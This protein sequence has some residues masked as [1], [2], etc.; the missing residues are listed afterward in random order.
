MQELNDEEKLELKKQNN[1]E[2]MR[3]YMK[4]R[5]HANIEDSQKRLNNFYYRKTNKD[6]VSLEDMKKYGNDFPI[7]CK[8]MKNILILKNKN[9]QLIKEILQNYLQ[10]CENDEH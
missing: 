8:V 7:V 1:R 9:P 10:E 2:Y 4:K 6:I 5:Y 3:E